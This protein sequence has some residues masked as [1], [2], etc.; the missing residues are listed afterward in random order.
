MRILSGPIES[1]LK[2]P[3]LDNKYNQWDNINN[4]IRGEVGRERREETATT[5]PE[6]DSHNKTCFCCGIK[7]D[8]SEGHHLCESRRLISHGGPALSLVISTAE[9][10]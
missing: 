10:N 7:L 4:Q 2:V 9:V 6:E 1:E 3:N 5:L 8:G